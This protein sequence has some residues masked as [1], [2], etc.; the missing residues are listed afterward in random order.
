MFGSTLS[1]EPSPGGAAVPAVTDDVLQVAVGVIQGPERQVLIS[2]RPPGVHLAGF[3]EF[4]GGKIETGEHVAQALHRE[5]REE[6]GI[7]TLSASPLIRVRHDY[8]ELRVSL[9]VWRV[10]SFSGE[11]RGLQGQAIRWVDSAALPGIAFPEANRPIVAAARLPGF[12]GI[13]D[14]AS[15]DR[16]TLRAQLAHLAARGIRLMQ[17]RASALQPLTGHRDW[18]SELI[19]ECRERGVTLLLNT[20]PD[21]ARELRSEG[22]HLTSAR[23]MALDRRPLDAAHW[24]AASCH[25]RQQL[26]HAER[27]GVDFAV[28]GPVAPTFTHPGLVPLGWDRFAE[29]V[30]RVKLPVYA[31]GGL[32]AGDLVRARDSGAQ[33]IAAIRGFLGTIG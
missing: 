24:V 14:P 16:E 1:T 4:P 25:N 15:S 21:L 7:D 22:V 13:I 20:D 29:L 2:R 32:A 23:L 33:G 28:L 19:A 30:D 9:D 12:Y 3:W 31:L 17:L 27:I 18:L 10:E 26:A 6:L 11:P 5:L 8:P